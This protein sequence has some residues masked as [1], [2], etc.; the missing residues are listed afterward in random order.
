MTVFRDESGKASGAN[1]SASSVSHEEVN[2]PADGVVNPHRESVNP[3]L[4][5]GV[6]PELIE[7]YLTELFGGVA[8]GIEVCEKK[9]ST[10]RPRTYVTT[11]GKDRNGLSGIAEATRF[12]T[13]LATLP[14][15]E[16]VYV[17]MTTLAAPPGRGQRGGANNAAAFTS[18]WSDGDFG[19][20]GHKD[21]GKDD[22]PLPPDA[23]TVRRI[24]RHAGMPEPS[25]EIMSGGGLNW[26]WI[27][28]EP[29][30]ITDRNTREQVRDA[31]R[32]CQK[33]I[34]AAA[35]ELGY[36]YGTGVFNLDRLMRPPGVINRKTAA[37]PRPTTGVFSGL[38]YTYD[39]LTALFPPTDEPVRGATGEWVNPVTGEIIPM[40]SA[41]ASADGR[42]RPGD[43]F[44]QQ[45]DWHELLM[46]LRWTYSHKTSDGVEYWIRPGKEAGEQH[47]A[48]LGHIPDKL[49]V[50]TDGAGLPSWRAYDKFSLYTYS[51][52]YSSAAVDVNDPQQVRE[53]FR[54]A[55]QDV[56]AQGYG[57]PLPSWN[58]PSSAPAEDVFAGQLNADG[59]VITHS[60]LAEVLAPSADWGG[61]LDVPLSEAETV[62]A[63]PAQQTRTPDGGG[64]AD[65][66]DG[67]DG[68]SEDGDGSGDALPIID[69]SN[70]RDGLHNLV[71]EIANGVLPETYVRDGQLVH[72]GVVSGARNGRRKKEGSA[73]ERIA[74]NLTP[75]RLR[76]LIAKHAVTVSFGKEGPKAKLPTEALC[77]AVLSISEW[78][79]LP[80]L[81]E[82]TR[83]PFVR[84]DGS[85]CQGR[86]YDEDTGI[87]LNV[88]DGFP[89]VP[90][91]P[92]D[93]DVAAAKDLLLN[94]VLGDFP[95]VSTGDR[96]NYLSLLLAPALRQVIGGLFPFGVVT[97]ASA[98]SGKSLL[99]EI[100]SRTYGG[101]G[102]TSTLSRQE[103]E[104][105]KVV[106]S[107]LMNDPH[108]VV[109]FDNIGKA[110]AVDSPVL[111]QLLT[112]SVWSDRVM[113]GNDIVS[114]VN[115]KL[116]LGTG[117]N[118]R[119]GGDM[120]SRS[121]FVRIDPQMERP[122]KRDTTSFVLGDLKT[123]LSRPENQVRIMHALL[124]LIRSWASAGMPR[125][126]HEMRTFTPWAQVVGGLLHHHAI[127]G[128]LTNTED[129]DDADDEAYEWAQFLGA[130]HG[131]HAGEW[132]TT[133]QLLAS[134]KSTQFEVMSGAVDPWGGA[135]PVKDNNQTYT[136]AALGAKFKYILDRPM[137]GWVLRRTVNRSTNQRLWR[138]EAAV[139][140]N[141][142]PKPRFEQDVLSAESD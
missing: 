104:V 130:W 129:V 29:V 8:G 44:N 43:V 82:I 36:S 133:A 67:A 72:V 55:A 109:T 141:Q 91:A 92:S 73:V 107:K 48:S 28:D 68:D 84:P 88:D 121:V 140:L 103:E 116:W 64:G 76:A 10:F 132:M 79:S 11:P 24:Y 97:A 7:R 45:V 113:G 106:T 80:D 26:I 94:Q 138:P 16:A 6:D 53:M 96:A 85:V 47:G 105:R 100:I 50:F 131:R 124:V 37:N 62:A 2:R 139:D 17:R 9:G 4:P 15:S 52:Y 99:T 102:E 86:G 69:I 41:G 90:D 108:S 110:H 1:P 123:W 42:Q 20:E 74:P 70:E 77:K 18:F 60:D 34:A 40:M 122:D 39:E 75:S 3:N 66:G 56:A 126:R 136:P 89:V 142:P 30:D 128:F 22:L 63:I 117:N 5:T 78:E 51:T 127:D 87:W 135:F 95:F 38:R 83:M 25:V 112:S 65:G 31:S 35:R 59:T 118:V 14:S 33:R 114:R 49:F 134:Y 101:N 137:H 71:K 58:P 98:S 13:R 23:E 61:L 46:R 81:V 32:R 12:I 19:T 120:G 27:L 93:E 57:E 115:D 21:S 54:T 119:L 125:T 111:A